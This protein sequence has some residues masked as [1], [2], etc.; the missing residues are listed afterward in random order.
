MI[1]RCHWLS[2]QCLN[3]TEQHFCPK[4]WAVLKEAAKWSCSNDM[5]RSMLQGIK[6]KTLWHR[7]EEPKKAILYKT[8][9]KIV[10][11]MNDI[12]NSI[13]NHKASNWQNNFRDVD[14]LFTDTLCSSTHRKQVRPNGLWWCLSW[15]SSLAFKSHH[16]VIH[17]CSHRCNWRL[18]A[19]D[20]I[21][22]IAIR[23]LCQ[24]AIT[25]WYPGFSVC[26]SHN[27][28]MSQVE[29]TRGEY[30]KQL[31]EMCVTQAWVTA[32]LILA[33]GFESLTTVTL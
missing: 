19:V 20:V 26:M 7:G 17:W 6:T 5:M 22:A 15:Q 9:W 12:Y 29:A 13:H 14:E 30:T 2:Q 24:N 32:A 4:L 21:G 11:S 1:K 28:S 33:E 16:G 3:L 8:F 23:R 18:S 31:P 10:F 27:V 25:R